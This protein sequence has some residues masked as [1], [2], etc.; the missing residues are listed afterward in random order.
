M[1]KILDKG[2]LFFA[3]KGDLN[4][5]TTIIKRNTDIDINM[6]D[7]YGRT[8]LSYASEIGSLSEIILAKKRDANPNIADKNGLTPLMYSAMNGY[9][10]CSEELVFMI[11]D[12][13]IIN[14][15]DN[16]GNTAL[17]HAAKHGRTRDV[18][19]LLRSGADKSIKN[20]ENL[21]ASSIARLY[22]WIELSK[23]IK[24]YST[25]L[26]IYKNIK[27]LQNEVRK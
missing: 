23:I 20:L 5:A 8:F 19:L 15:I 22:G 6:Q 25:D 2:V 14:V 13:K 26:T 11:K 1:E 16:E 18:L 3:R 12:K 9:T 4:S 17:M 10:R 21:T 24:R 27:T 7:R